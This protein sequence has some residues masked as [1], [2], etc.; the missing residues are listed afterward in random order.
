VSAQ[1]ERFRRRLLAAEARRMSALPASFSA[2]R[3]DGA[4]PGP[5]AIRKQTTPGEPTGS[6]RGKRRDLKP[7]RSRVGVYGLAK[8]AAERPRKTIARL[9]RVIEQL[10]DEKREL[11]DRLVLAHDSLRYFG[12][13]TFSMATTQKRS[14]GRRR[15]TVSSL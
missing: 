13:R 6:A 8:P 4:T 5:V 11:R 15:A 2:V 12:V 1:F 14:R 9:Y 7:P 3:M 10:K